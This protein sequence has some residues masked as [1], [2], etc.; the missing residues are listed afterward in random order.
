MPCEFVPG[1]RRWKR[2]LPNTVGVD[3]LPDEACVMI[4]GFAPAR[5]HQHLA[6]PVE[7]G[8]LAELGVADAIAAS[9]ARQLP[10]HRL[11]REVVAR[12]SR[13]PCGTRARRGR[14]CAE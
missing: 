11:A 12:A 2:K 14:C 6:R 10:E 4:C 8:V 9:P 1:S 13:S 7:L 5:Q 3:G